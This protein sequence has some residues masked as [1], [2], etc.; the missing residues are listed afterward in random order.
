MADA[1]NFDKVGEF[2]DNMNQAIAN[3]RQGAGLPRLWPADERV[4]Q[5]KYI[6]EQA[7]IATGQGRP[8]PPQVR[9]IGR[10]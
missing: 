8:I 7:E 4:A 2:Q 6:G 5:I 3:A 1:V 9:Y 10:L